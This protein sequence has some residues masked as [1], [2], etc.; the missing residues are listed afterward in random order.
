[1]KTTEIPETFTAPGLS[2]AREKLA[3]DSLSPEEK[4]DCLRYMDLKYFEE[5]AMF[6]ANVEG[7]EK[8]FKKGKAEG[9]E[10]GIEKRYRKRYR[11]NDKQAPSSTSA[12]SSSKAQRR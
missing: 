4:K 6:A 10:E 3:L 7:L 2:E 1:M 9:I 12:Q 11:S 8:G 5:N